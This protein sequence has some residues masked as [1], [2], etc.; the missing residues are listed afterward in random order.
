MTVHQKRNVY[1]Q[2]LLDCSI[3]YAK[4]EQFL[5]V[6]LLDVEGE[7]IYPRLP[8]DYKPKSASNYSHNGFV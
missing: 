8:N 7:Y 2:T 4:E 1:L 3:A 6:N 5:C